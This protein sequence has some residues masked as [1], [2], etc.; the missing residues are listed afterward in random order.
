MISVVDVD[1]WLGSYAICFYIYDEKK[2]VDMNI[3]SMM[4]ILF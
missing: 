1:T 4:N 3:L 2:V